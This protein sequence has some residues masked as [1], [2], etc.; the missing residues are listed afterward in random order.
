LAASPGN[1]VPAL[2]T[3]GTPLYIGS[4]GMLGWTVVSNGS[5]SAFNVAWLPTGNGYGITPE[6]GNYSLDLTGYN[7]APLF[8]GVEQ[9]VNLAA[10]NYVLTFYIGV[11]NSNG[12]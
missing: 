7:D 3:D 2:N 12:L 10:G 5:G 6:N 9:S 8:S 1:C 4:T 11:D